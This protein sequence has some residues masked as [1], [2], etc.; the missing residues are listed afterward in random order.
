MVLNHPFHNGG[1]N[2]VNTLC[3]AAASPKQSLP[4][5]KRTERNSHILL[6]TVVEAIEVKLMLTANSKKLPLTWCLFFPQLH[7]D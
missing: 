5:F 3:S 4:K 2:R 1:G 6:L 7:T